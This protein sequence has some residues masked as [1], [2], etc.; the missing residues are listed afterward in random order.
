LFLSFLLSLEAGISLAGPVE[1]VLIDSTHSWWGGSRGW[2][3]GLGARFRLGSSESRGGRFLFSCRGLRGLFRLGL[4]EVERGRA[5]IEPVE[6]H[7]SE[8][9]SRRW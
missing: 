1:G 5:A 9:L 6:H 2:S 7:R 4:I 3:S 8:L